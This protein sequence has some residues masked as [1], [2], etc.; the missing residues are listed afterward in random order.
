MDEKNREEFTSQEHGTEANTAPEKK[1]KKGFYLKV[2]ALAL[3]C[4][5]LGGIVGAGCVMCSG[6]LQAKL[7]IGKGIIYALDDHEDFSITRRFGFGSVPFGRGRTSVDF[8]DENNNYIGVSVTDS[9]ESDEIPSGALIKDVEKGSP[10]DKGGLQEND[11]VTMVNNVKISTSDE[12]A[13]A[14]AK[15]KPGDV[16]KLTVYRQGQTLD[17]DVT[18]GGQ[19]I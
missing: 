7:A 10:A 14:V 17:V 8:F 16:L 18:V 11:I 5:I 6:G 4:S 15:A 9:K 19:S 12:L 13:E 2:V 1:K 3:C